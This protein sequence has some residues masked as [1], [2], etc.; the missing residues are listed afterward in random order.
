MIYDL[1]IKNGHVVDPAAGIDTV[2]NVGFFNGLSCGLVP[3]DAQ[4]P[5]TRVIDASGLYVF[6]GLV[7]FHTHVARRISSIC[8][9]PD[10]FLADGVTACADAGSVGCANYEAFRSGVAANSTVH[11]R[12]FLSVCS[13]GQPGS[14]FAEDFSPELFDEKKIEK[15]FCEYPEELLG[16]KIRMGAEVKGVNDLEPLRAAKRLA[17]K[18]GVNVVVHSSNPPDTMEALCGILGAGDVCCHCYHGKGKY[19]IIGPDGKVL[20][21][22]REARER[23]VIFDAA[24]GNTN[25]NHEVAI[26]ALKDGFLP[27][28]ISTDACDANY[29]IDGY[30]RSLPSVMSKYLWLGMSLTDVVRA[31][32]E[33]PAKHMKLAKAGSLAP[34]MWGDAAVFR[35]KEGKPRYLDN[36]QHERFG[37]RMLVPMLTVSGGEIAY[38]SIE[39]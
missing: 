26:A 27:D 5:A 3:D 1:I 11:V 13:Y 28:I 21:G 7:D 18:L 39:L 29:G 35:L 22:V 19:N 12:T 33:T 36:F 17:E 20:P 4:A 25:Y 34:G 16:L 14:N 8:L 24:N 31:A 9:D 10:W 30:A 37:D 6:P 23:G 2:G 38:R 15:L 32:T